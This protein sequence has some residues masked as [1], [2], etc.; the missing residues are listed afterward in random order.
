LFHR[1]LSGIRNDNR[2]SRVPFRIVRDV[3]GRLIY[4]D[5]EDAVI[6]YTRDET[7]PELFTPDFTLALSYFLAVQ[8]APR[9]T[10]GDPFKLSEKVLNFYLAHLSR[11]KA[12][13]R[14]E[15]QMEQEP[16]SEF[17]RGRD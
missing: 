12:I 8:I 10:A 2:Q 13:A 15:E 6:E 9:L 3:S 5:A 4:T 7:N 11:A 16:E 1:I 17:T 14:N